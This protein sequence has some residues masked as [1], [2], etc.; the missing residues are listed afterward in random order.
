MSKALERSGRS[1]L[2]DA[3]NTRDYAAPAG[4]TSILFSYFQL[5]VMVAGAY[6]E[7]EA[8]ID[9]IEGNAAEEA[10]V[11]SFLPVRGNFAGS[12]FQVEWRHLN[13]EVPDHVMF[14]PA[15]KTEILVRPDGSSLHLHASVVLRGELFSMGGSIGMRRRLAANVYFPTML[16]CRGIGDRK[17]LCSLQPVGD[18]YDVVDAAALLRSEWVGP[19][20]SRILQSYELSGVSGRLDSSASLILEPEFSLLLGNLRVRSGPISAT[21]SSELVEKAA[22]QLF[23]N[24]AKLS[25]RVSVGDADYSVV[26]FN[27][28]KVQ[29]LRFDVHAVKLDSGSVHRLEIASRSGLAQLTDHG[30][31]ERFRFYDALDGGSDVWLGPSETLPSS[32]PAL[33]AKYRSAISELLERRGISKELADYIEFARYSHGEPCEWFSFDTKGALL[34]DELCRYIGNELGEDL[35]SVL[36]RAEEVHALTKDLGLVYRS[37]RDVVFGLSDT[38]SIQHPHPRNLAEA[39]FGGVGQRDFRAASQQALRNALFGGVA[40][41]PDRELEGLVNRYCESISEVAGSCHVESTPWYRRWLDSL[42]GLVAVSSSHAAG[43]ADSRITDDQAEAVKSALSK[44]DTDLPEC[45]DQVHLALA[46]SV[47]VTLAASSSGCLDDRVPVL[48][49]AFLI[50]GS[51]KPEFLTSVPYY[52]WRELDG[53]SPTD[54]RATELGTLRRK[55]LSIAYQAKIHAISSLD[56]T[57]QEYEAHLSA[58]GAV[59]RGGSFGVGEI[60]PQDLLF[61]SGVFTELLESAVCGGARAACGEAGSGG[62]TIRTANGSTLRFDG[63]NEISLEVGRSVIHSATEAAVISDVPAETQER[64][65]ALEFPEMDTQLESLL[66]QLRT[67]HHVLDV[68][69]ETM[70]I[71]GYNVLAGTDFGPVDYQGLLGVWRSLRESVTKPLTKMLAELTVA[72]DAGK[73]EVSVEGGPN[74]PGASIAISFDGQPVTWDRDCGE[75]GV[76]PNAHPVNVFAEIYRCLPV[77]LKQHILGRILELY[78]TE[79]GPV[80]VAIRLID[81][82]SRYVYATGEDDLDQILVDQ[83]LPYLAQV[84][85]VLDSIVRNRTCP[86][87]SSQVRQA[88][89]TAEPFFSLRG[90][91]G[92]AQPR[93]GLLLPM[94]ACSTPTIDNRQIQRSIE[95]TLR[96]TWAGDERTE[97]TLAFSGGA[98]VSPDTIEELVETTAESMGIGGEL[99]LWRVYLPLVSK[100]IN[101]QSPPG[102]PE[103]IQLIHQG[104]PIIDRYIRLESI[105][106]SVDVISNDVR[107]QFTRWEKRG[108]DASLVQQFLATVPNDQSLKLN[109]DDLQSVCYLT[110]RDKYR[111]PLSLGRLTSEVLRAASA[112][113]ESGSIRAEIE[114][115]LTTTVLK[116]IGDSVADDYGI[117]P[118]IGADSKSMDLRGIACGNPIG[119]DAVN[120]WKVES[121]V[122]SLIGSC[123]EVGK[124]KLLRLLSEESTDSPR[125]A[126]SWIWDQGSSVSVT[127]RPP[128]VTLHL[129]NSDSPVC[130]VEL[131]LESIRSGDTLP[132]TVEGQVGDCFAAFAA[133]VAGHLSSRTG[134]EVSFEQDGAAP[135]GEFSV[136]YGGERYPLDSS[137]L[138]DPKTVLSFVES[139]IANESVPKSTEDAVAKLRS[140][141]GPWVEVSVGRDEIPVNVDGNVVYTVS[142]STLERQHMLEMARVAASIVAARIDIDGLECNGVDCRLTVPGGATLRLNLLRDFRRPE[143]LSRRIAAELERVVR[144][145]VVTAGPVTCTYSV[146]TF[147]HG[148]ESIEVPMDAVLEDPVGVVASIVESPA[149]VRALQE[150][151]FVQDVRYLRD[152][153]VSMSFLGQPLQIRFDEVGADN[154]LRIVGGA[155]RDRFKRLADAEC[156]NYLLSIPDRRFGV[157]EISGIKVSC[158]AQ[159]PRVSFTVIGESGGYKQSFSDL[160]ADEIQDLESTLLAGVEQFVESGLRNEWAAK[161]SQLESAL[162]SRLGVYGPY[163]VSFPESIGGETRLL[164]SGVQMAVFGAGDLKRVL[165]DV[166]PLVER[167]ARD[168]LMQKLSA[169]LSAPDSVTATCSSICRI[170]FEVSGEVFTLEIG[171]D[172]TPDEIASDLWRYLLQRE[173][174]RQK[175]T[176]IVRDAL[177]VSEHIEFAGDHLVISVFGVRE[178]LYLNAVDRPE[179]LGKS[180]EGI[181]AKGVVA[182]LSRNLQSIDP[183]LRAELQGSSVSVYLA[184]NPHPLIAAVSI[185]RLRKRPDEVIRD[186]LLEVAGSQLN[187]AVNDRVVEGLEVVLRSVSPRLQMKHQRYGANHTLAI[188]YVSRDRSV[189]PIYVQEIQAADADW[190]PALIETVTRK[191]AIYA[192]QDALLTVGRTQVANI[193]SSLDRVALSFPSPIVLNC[194]DGGQLRG[195]FELLGRPFVIS[196]GIELRPDGTAGDLLPDIDYQ[197][198]QIV[199]SLES[200]FHEVYGDYLPDLQITKIDVRERAI[201]IEMSYFVSQLGIRASGTLVLSRSGLE[202]KLD[203]SPEDWIRSETCHYLSKYIMDHPQTLGG[204]YENMFVAADPTCSASGDLNVPII[205]VLNTE[206]GSLEVPGGVTVAWDGGLSAYINTNGLLS[207][208]AALKSYLGGINVGGTELIAPYYLFEDG[209]LAVFLRSRIETDFLEGAGSISAEY[210]ISQKG[211]DIRGS[212]EFVSDQWIDLEKLSIGR[213]GLSLNPELRELSLLGSATV[214]PGDLNGDIARFNGRATIPL[215]KVTFIRLTGE[216]WAKPTGAMSRGSA[217]IG[218]ADG[219][220]ITDEAPGT[221]LVDVSLTQGIPGLE[222]VQLN[223]NLRIK[224]HPKEFIRVSADATMLGARLAEAKLRLGK[225]FSGEF[226]SSADLKLLE[227]SGD[228]SVM[229]GLILD[230]FA[231]S[232]E[233]EGLILVSGKAAIDAGVSA[234]IDPK[235]ALDFVPKFSVTVEDFS[236]LTEVLLALLNLDPTQ[237]DLNAFRDARLGAGGGNGGSPSQ[238]GSDGGSDGK[239]QERA[240]SVPPPVV[241]PAEVNALNILYERVSIRG[242]CTWTETYDCSTF[243]VFKTCDEDRQ[244][245]HVPVDNQVAEFFSLSRSC[246]RPGGYSFVDNYRRALQTNGYS[247][248]RKGD[249]NFTVHHSGG[250]I[251]LLDIRGSFKDERYLFAVPYMEPGR[252]AV[253]HDAAGNFSVLKQGDPI[254]AHR[255]FSGIEDARNLPR[256]D[257]FRQAYQDT[258]ELADHKKLLLGKLARSR[259]ADVSFSEDAILLDD[260]R[261]A[262]LE[263]IRPGVR[264]ENQ[265]KLVLSANGGSSSFQVFSRTPLFDGLRDRVG[266][267]PV[268]RLLSA[269]DCPPS[270]T[271]ANDC[272]AVV[273]LESH[274]LFFATYD[275]KNGAPA[276]IFDKHDASSKLGTWQLSGLA[277]RA[278]DQFGFEGLLTENGNFHEWDTYLQTVLEKAAPDDGFFLMVGAPKCEIVGAAGASGRCVLPDFAEHVAE[279]RNERV[280]FGF[281]SGA[282]VDAQISLHSRYP[283]TQG[284]YC[285]QSAEVTKLQDFWSK[286][287]FSNET[288]SEVIHGSTEFK[289]QELIENILDEGW[290][291]PRNDNELW[292]ANPLTYFEVTSGENLCTR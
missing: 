137:L 115:A 113:V 286:K 147:H 68:D 144:N 37:W 292:W 55:L 204:I 283:S 180:L 276:V 73:F 249:G 261:L 66:D 61:G 277:A 142:R 268:E 199:P 280:R 119:L 245:G 4:P 63:I 221:D 208:E 219:C 158:I 176:G 201:S 112:D 166:G 148:G 150:L 155:F 200:V 149:A 220:R 84:K 182:Y 126:V 77:D 163:A 136:K 165:F 162:N 109:C 271:F 225:D 81:S 288:R 122:R 14:V 98:V 157:F 238:G 269:L 53:K 24:T 153:T 152:R 97:S 198:L 172:T 106:T 69:P 17:P 133:T 47:H 254:P 16:V 125:S 169:F 160:T 206:F 11:P 10:L 29:P 240:A 173:S 2:L 36:K 255:S 59:G 104:R 94:F 111:L 121:T 186:V 235:G 228:V 210:A 183:G 8:H 41:K 27:R 76:S 272:G 246:R 20:T 181:A 85:F 196:G 265:A 38:Y 114:N 185:E 13:A 251:T 127:H 82:D 95:F 75:F 248:S 192:A 140:A 188:H 252:L 275:L 171:G 43:I 244:D 282:G 93:P 1:W 50:E 231:F 278:R 31:P 154:L 250:H 218:E 175:I 90:Q 138:A 229:P 236:E 226:S 48:T 285:F 15:G 168:F 216:L 184:N 191:V 187:D 241:P 289:P 139:Y 18:R 213:F 256:L 232:G 203:F 135:R 21:S 45:G 32:V 67:G 151:P 5:A 3:T 291:S 80:G 131:G 12:Q 159:A 89:R 264:S 19:E 46:N 215:D 193:C 281:L 190:Y 128:A 258:E 132:A 143:V 34:P 207:F 118:P 39:L 267:A 167:V 209:Q 9:S 123:L 129:S 242:D 290:A 263:I 96:A 102:M 233:V 262:L 257:L 230:G 177:P 79:F 266:G 91:P 156:Q 78:E 7:L 28:Y 42:V 227:I 22:E 30:V 72:E 284:P 197:N 56:A 71:S 88:L 33:D 234:T 110:Y 237:L 195:E 26:A 224:N 44:L 212:I 70:M 40:Y 101:L 23:A 57:T 259:L 51:G 100:D 83:G 52:F 35:L 6:Q 130:A 117:E 222:L 108:G 189:L 179:E 214:S 279:I 116:F 62:L 25:R 74:K 270:E 92:T 170:A 145:S 141:F 65:P 58:A 120:V 287:T 146:C 211:L 134:L 174:V 239:S 86:I 260:G 247:L 164:K 103:L 194:A 105:R 223:G 99:S 107:N 217:C 243:L 205:V 64:L 54:V 161:R 273:D 124:R 87:E 178:A 60:E 49:D 202:T 253:V 274:L